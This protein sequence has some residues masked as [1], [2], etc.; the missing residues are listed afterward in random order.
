MQQNLREL[1]NYSTFELVSL[2]NDQSKTLTCMAA[3][4]I[5]IDDG[6]MIGPRS[7]LATLC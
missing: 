4:G 3:G 1:S 6:V 5:T 2:L 7:A